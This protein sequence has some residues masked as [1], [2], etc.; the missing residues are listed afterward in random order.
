[1]SLLAPSRLSPDSSFYLFD[2]VSPALRQLQLPPPE[3]AQSP[4]RNK[5]SNLVI[6]TK[7]KKKTEKKQHLHQFFILTFGFTVAI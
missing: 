5:Q 7:Q 2:D 3:P 1:M 6:Y 4:V